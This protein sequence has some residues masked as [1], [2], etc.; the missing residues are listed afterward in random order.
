MAALRW[1][2]DN[3]GA[4]GGDADRVT[5]MGGSA[6]AM[7]VNALM[8]APAPTASSTAPSPSPRRAT[9]R[10]LTLDE[11]RGQGA[12]AFPDLTADQLRA[13]PA[14]DLLSLDLQHVLG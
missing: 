6:G 8:A 13:L 7:S 2:R 5:L 10:P 1:V 3:V 11:V 12:A 4:F 14:D 9:L